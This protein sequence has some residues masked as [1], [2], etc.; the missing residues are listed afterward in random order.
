MAFTRPLI[1][2]EDLAA[3]MRSGEPLVIVDCR[4]VTG[5][6]REA[7]RQMYLAGH[8][9][10]AVYFHLDDDM[11]APPAEHGGRH[12]LPDADTFA[13]KLGAAGVGPGVK[14]VA[15]DDNGFA[16]PRFW[17]LLRYFGHDEV[18]L[19]D[20]GFPAWA[21][22][23][24]PVAAEVAP[25][26]VRT[27]V[28][29]PRPE[30]VAAMEEVR[31]R[32]P[33]ITVIDSRS[34]ARFAGAPDPLDERSGH[35]PGAINRPWTESLGPDGR[36]RPAAEQAARFAGLEPGKTIVHC[37]SGVTACANLV[38]WPARP[39]PGCTWAAGATGAAIPRTRWRRTDFPHKRPHGGLLG[40]HAGACVPQG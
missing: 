25:H 35:V 8:I 10:G 23:G 31:D 4:F 33:E 13:A 16:A 20:G 5:P 37:G 22:A 30:L 26:E 29:H 9:P 11:A 28:P 18:S 39:G 32:P 21:A 24:L 17:W 38:E 40:C 3:L 2:A 1:A 14:V 19:L 7:G 12:P 34:A 6:D 15:Y 36:W 27:F